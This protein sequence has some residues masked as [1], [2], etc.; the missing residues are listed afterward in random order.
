MDTDLV[1]LFPQI[2]IVHAGVNIQLREDEY[3]GNEPD[4][5]IVIVVNKDARIATS[6]NLTITPVMLSVANSSNLFPMN[7]VLPDDNGGRSPVEAG[8]RTYHIS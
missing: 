5:S 6:V 2:I 4:E 3:R 8:E 1:S 7:V